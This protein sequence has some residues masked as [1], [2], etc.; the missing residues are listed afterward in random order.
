MCSYYQI[1]ANLGLLTIMDAKGLDEHDTIKT[2]ETTYKQ[3][4]VN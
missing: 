2:L 1:T 4:E 3:Y